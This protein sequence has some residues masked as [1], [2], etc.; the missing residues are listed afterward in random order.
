MDTVTDKFQ[1]QIRE[2]Q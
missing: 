2:I 1:N